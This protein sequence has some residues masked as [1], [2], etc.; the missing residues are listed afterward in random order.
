MLTDQL[1]FDYDPNAKAEKFTEF[2]EYVVPEKE[3][4]MVIAEYIA[5]VFAKHL[6]WEK[7]MGL[8]GIGCNGR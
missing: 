6:S 1:P 3:A 2:L 5:Y 8:Y 7:C 4:R